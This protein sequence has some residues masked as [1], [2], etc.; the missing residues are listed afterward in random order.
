MID[1]VALA[2]ILPLIIEGLKRRGEESHIIQEY[3]CKI[4]AAL[5]TISIRP[6]LLFIHLNDLWTA[7]II[8]LSSNLNSVRSIAS[9]SLGTFAVNSGQDTYDF[10]KDKI[11]LLLSSIDSE[12]Q[13]RSGAAQSLAELISAAGDVEVSDM[14]PKLLNEIKIGN[15][16]E[17][18]GFSGVFMFL[19]NSLGIDR[20]KKYIYIIIKSLLN[21]L[22]E[23]NDDLRT[24][25]YNVLAKIITDFSIISKNEIINILLDYS[26]NDDD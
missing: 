4:I 18:E 12:P 7:F 8:A 1:D 20:I 21:V 3:S 22:E 13:L 9:K 5:P 11:Y 25:C 26:F 15:I 23:K 19:P 17:K 2:L 10:L 24:S 6:D 14:M 16:Y